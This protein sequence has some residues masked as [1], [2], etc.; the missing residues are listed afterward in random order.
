MNYKKPIT[1]VKQ[2]KN[3]LKEFCKQYPAV[4]PE[5]DMSTVVNTKDHSRTFTDEQVEDIH[6][7]LD[8]IYSMIDDPCLYIIE[9]L[10]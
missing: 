10:Q 5:D 6:A 8:E 9:E 3:F 1:T 2:S 7:R 4:H